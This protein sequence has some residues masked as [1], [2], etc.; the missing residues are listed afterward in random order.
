MRDGMRGAWSCLSAGFLVALFA[1]P[2]VDAAAPPFPTPPA[3][4]AG[5]GWTVEPVAFHGGSAPPSLVLDTANRPHLQYCP[6]GE[7]WY[8][9]RDGGSWAG[10]LV[11]ETV[12]GGVCGGIAL[13]PGE[14]PYLLVAIPPD[15]DPGH[16]YLAVKNGLSWQF[17]QRPNTAGS[18]VVDSAGVPHLIVALKSS[19]TTWSLRYLSL[20]GALW[21]EEDIELFPFGGA[22]LGLSWGS[23]VLD[24]ADNPRVL[25]YESVR[26]DV[27]YAFRDTSGWHVEV[28]EHIG[29][30]NIVGR[31]GSLAL[32]GAGNP[33]AAYT[34]RV[35]SQTVEVRYANRGGP[36]WI[37]EVVSEPPLSLGDGAFSPSLGFGPAGP[38][39]A[40]V[41]IEQIDLARVIYSADLRLAVSS[42]G[43]WSRETVL[44]GFF[45]GTMRQGSV[46]Q[47]PSLATDRCGNPRLAFYLGSDLNP[48]VFYATKGECVP[49]T[50]TA[51]L[52]VEPRTLNLRSR[53]RWITATVTL[54]S[55]TAA[56]VD[57][58]SLA[59][60][61]IA[62]DRVQ[63]L[64]DTAIQLKIPR[65]E[66]IATL[67]DPPKFGVPVTLTLTGEWEDGGSF[68]AMDSIRVIRSGKTP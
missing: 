17:I 37:S 65:G 61:G 30:L 1:L 49:T 8:V 42:A 6:P 45:D 31:E 38:V 55:A 68:T 19:S 2:M 4:S 33:H 13:G 53:G 26:G 59:V 56:D 64:N 7:D 39:I 23:M 50:A 15:W 9:V 28:V 25:Y 27:R 21:T 10:E 48:G 58:A 41:R 36:G 46:P 40:Y 44:D 66:L 54:D 35:T 32:D 60:D 34:V 12:G 43:T 11:A 67:P 18:I 57:L 22:S 16:R 62:P 29:A 63:V 47:F 5:P 14:V 3:P 51:T 24:A 20:S 52:R